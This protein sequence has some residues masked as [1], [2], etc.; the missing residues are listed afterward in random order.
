MIRVRQATVEDE[1]GV[2]DLLRQLLFP[3]GGIRSE[4]T[5]D[6]QKETPMNVA[7]QEIIGS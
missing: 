2:I 3:F 1:A 4:S 5:I 6:W 7:V